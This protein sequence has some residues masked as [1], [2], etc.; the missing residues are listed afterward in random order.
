MVLDPALGAHLRRYVPTIFALSSGRPPVAIAVIR[1]SGPRAGAALSALGVKIP[2]PREARL[3]RIRDPRSGEIID[4]ALVLWFPAP[5]SETGED[6]TELQ[7]HGGRAVIAATRRALKF[8]VSPAEAGE[9]PAAPS[10][11]ASSI[12]PRSRASPTW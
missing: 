11:T 4:E 3:A 10:R 12:S 1:I 5:H 7:A 2:A 9:L 6:V 8:T